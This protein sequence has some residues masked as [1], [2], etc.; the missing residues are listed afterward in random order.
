MASSF[1]RGDAAAARQRLPPHLPHSVGATPSANTCPLAPSP[2]CAS[3]SRLTEARL[4]EDED[5]TSPGYSTAPPD[6]TAPPARPSACCPCPSTHNSCLHHVP[7]DLA[8][9]GPQLPLPDILSTHVVVMANSDICGSATETHNTLGML[10]ATMAIDVYA[11]HDCL[12]N[13]QSALKLNI[14]KFKDVLP[15]QR[16]RRSNLGPTRFLKE[17]KLLVLAA[18]KD[19]QFIYTEKPELRT[20]SS[21]PAQM[22]L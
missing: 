18:N 16:P 12:T 13:S 10:G 9:V 2:S 8:A 4:G 20:D 11:A 21:N 5:A 17:S 7:P 14:K 6:S 1:G 19:L 22:L 3:P 15:K